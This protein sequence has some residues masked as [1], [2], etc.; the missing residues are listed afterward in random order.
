VLLAAIPRLEELPS[1]ADRVPRDEAL[2]V[3][4]GP[5]LDR[6]LRG[7]AIDSY[8]V[9][10]RPGDYLHAV[11]EQQGVDVVVSLLDPSGSELLVVDSPNGDVGPEPVFL[12]AR[13]AGYHRLLVQ[14][15]DRNALGRYAVRIE[16]LRPASEV[17]RSR[18]AA[19]A[20]VAHGEALRSKGG[21]VRL[22]QA[23]T[24]YRS[25]LQHWRHLGEMRDEALTWRRIGQTCRA[26]ADLRGARDAFEQ[27]LT[28]YRKLRDEA[29][30]A[31]LLNDAGAVHQSLA[32]LRQAE[33]DFLRARDLFHAQ[34][35]RRG[36]AAALNNLA[37]IYDSQADLDKALAL[38]NQALTMWRDLGDR[39]RQA[40][41]LHNL[42]T[43]YSLL[44]RLREAL[45]LLN[46]ALRL[47]RAVGDRRN[48][49]ATLTAVGWVY[50]LEGNLPVALHHYDRALLLRRQEGDLLGEAATLDR[51]GTAL[52]RMGR[53]GEALDSYR[54]ALAILTR[55]GEAL[56]QAHT[57]A[58]LG[59]LYDAC[60]DPRQA[61][62]YE[63]RALHI[64]HQAGDR[65]A[66]AHTLLG[67]ARAARQFGDLGLARTRI[68]A[69]LDLLESLRGATPLEELRI[70]YLASRHDYYEFAIDLLMA[71]ELREPGRGFAAQA[72]ATSERGRARGLLDVVAENDATNFR[73]R[74]Q[75]APLG[76]PE[77]QR[78]VLD[79][80]TLL[81]EYALGEE[82]S[83]LWVVGAH[84]VASYQLPGRAEIEARAR[85]LYDL[86]PRS[87]K[88]GIKEQERFAAAALS[89][90]ILAPAVGSLGRKRLL[91]VADGALQYI[92]FG[93]LPVLSPEGRR[94]PLLV[95]HEVVHLPSASVLARL[96]QQIAGRP[97]PPHLVAVVADPVFDRDDSRLQRSLIP[98]A[99][100]AIAGTSRAESELERS[101]EDL[102]LGHFA[103]LP[104]ARREA[105]AILSLVPPGE[106]LPAL[107]FA[108]SR[109]TVLSG[110]LAD[111]RIVH[112]ATHGLLNAEHPDLSGLVLA[113]VD[114]RGRL[115]DGF[116][117]VHEVYGL[118]LPADLVV[119][120]AC[121]TALGQEVR[122][123]GLLGLTQGFFHAGA[124]RVL[125]SLWNV[126][127]EATAELMSR[128]Y[129]GVLRRG[130]PPSR[131]LRE[132]QLSMLREPRWGAPYY[133]AGFT[134]QGEWK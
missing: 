29:A 1:P 25:A 18:A 79:P 99:S 113:L 124:A 94:I 6:F 59:W 13:F 60:G 47:R 80:D 39:S 85:R 42:G 102:G 22:D 71:L 120:S 64:F 90:A 14:A 7:G 76:V 55:A 19:A 23:L 3:R 72:F 105:E 40:A 2:K 10:L 28:L 97:E 20:D 16:E 127:D 69:T 37:A 63:E 24:A 58:N 133:W 117:R 66:E 84:S 107:G 8:L 61:A 51:R 33:E 95:G 126:N 73:D 82:R 134:L 75:P 48:E 128:F 121:R 57:L 49:A 118:H 15:L 123:E 116:L 111:Y 35:N 77:I 34:G 112:F 32:E 4:R 109:E 30:E 110:R 89:D 86:L 68:A 11:V 65:H 17:D 104:Q 44:G 67:L 100:V 70:S 52:V 108:A 26:M 93:A 9:L 62:S 27:A 106:A 41:T 88:R 38:Y 45:E 56:G 98:V 50:Y 87:Q 91:I 31:P 122:G 5:A 74:G 43:T 46:Q 21:Q 101:A 130:L 53:T 96:R 78:E 125:V 115:R 54:R 36:E 129:R 119:L 92:P 81:L 83:F 132:A 114:E 103:R 12:V 131:A